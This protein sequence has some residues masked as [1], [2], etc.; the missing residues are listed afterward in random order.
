MSICNEKGV[1]SII[2]F[3]NAPSTVKLDLS[4]IENVELLFLLV[5]LEIL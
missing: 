3:V 4:E 2:D 1:D 5:C